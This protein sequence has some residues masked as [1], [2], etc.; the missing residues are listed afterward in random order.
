[1]SHDIRYIL[2]RLSEL[3]EGRLTPV[4]VKKGLNQ[5]QQDVPQLPALFKPKKI[6]VLAAKKDPEHPMAGYAVGGGA[7]ESTEPKTALEETMQGIE[8]DMLSKVKKSLVAYMDMIADKQK[9]QREIQNKAVDDVE[10]MN[11]AKAGEQDTH[12]E[13][14]EEIAPLVATV[15][16]A[17]AGAAIEKGMEKMSDQR[18]P[19][20]VYHLDDGGVVECWSD[21]KG[22]F[23]LRR[24]GRSLPAKFN[25]INDTDVAMKLWQAR[26]KK[27]SAA[28]SGS[29]DYIEEK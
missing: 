2:Q 19:A 6:S 1:M 12:E 4:S 3:E 14:I 22:Q 8:E 27:M 7:N 17:L 24:D 5:Q 29:A 23:E 21:D 26:R 10:D 28:D 9:D 15:G 25:N 11:P 13:E 20:K 16:R 18:S